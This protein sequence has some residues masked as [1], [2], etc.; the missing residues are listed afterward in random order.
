VRCQGAVSGFILIAAPKAEL[1][2]ALNMNA[3]SFQRFPNDALR[4][5]LAEIL[6]QQTDASVLRE[7]KRVKTHTLAPIMGL[8][9]T[10]HGSE[11]I[12]RL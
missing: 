3:Q 6:Q 10:Y 4:H 9:R 7:R 8:Q 12:G 11:A 5:V 2:D 1:Q